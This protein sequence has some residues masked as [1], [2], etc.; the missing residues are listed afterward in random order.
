MRDG[1]I[2][3]SSS[4]AFII[5][6]KTD[7]RRNLLDFVVETIYLVGE[8]NA[9]YKCN[10]TKEEMIRGAEE[11]N[12][13]WEPGESKRVS[14]GDED[15]TTIGRVFDYMLR[16]GGESESFVWRFAEYLR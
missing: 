12:D 6:N 14:F 15:G 13:Y 5:T 3:N 4:T 7:E 16:E 10:E 11:E 9:V 8:F 1:F 2:S